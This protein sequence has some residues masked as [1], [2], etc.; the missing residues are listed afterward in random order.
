MMQVL[1]K[2]NPRGRQVQRS[3]LGTAITQLYTTIQRQCQLALYKDCNIWCYIMQSRFVFTCFFLLIFCSLNGQTVNQ[4]TVSVSF[5]SEDNATMAASDQ[6][7]SG[8]LI[9]PQEK[10]KIVLS[11]KIIYPFLVLFGT[12]GN[13]MII[14]I[15]KRTAL[16]SSMSV[17]FLTLAA[18][19]LVLLCVTCFKVWIDL[20]FDFNLSAQ[21][22]T[23]CKL[24]MFLIYVS[25]VLSAWTLVA[26][27][28]QRAVCVMFPHRANVLCTVGKSKAIVVSMVLFIT[29][30]HAHI[31]YGFHV[32]I[33]K[34]RETCIL[35]I[36]YLRFFHEIWLWADVLIFS[37]LPWLCLA[38]S[39]SLLV[40]KLRLS[41]REAKLSP[42]SGQADRINDRKKKATSISITLI[43]VSTAF[44]L[45]TFPISCYQIIAFIAWMD[46]SIGTIRSSR[47]VYYTH[48]IGFPLWY[49]NGC[50]N[51]YIYCLTGSKFRRE[52]KQILRCMFH[53][54][55]DKQGGNT[56]ASTMSSD[57]ETRFT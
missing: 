9:T 21:N 47:V 14:V 24:V 11:H 19:D 34:G 43:A 42:G 22:N 23:L 31:L 17:F 36:E 30:I 7:P 16:T 5:E 46:G 38:V 8:G 2:R 3:D 56:T 25:G 13:V 40:W 44:L 54:D 57:N 20:V 45:L 27:T 37:L 51:F 29:A 39:N 28:A 6:Q 48:Q 52:A 32:G 33:Y 4:S 12:F 1:H 55:S 15:H 49:A 18:S 35:R 41:L 53:D 26:M 10:E 50:I